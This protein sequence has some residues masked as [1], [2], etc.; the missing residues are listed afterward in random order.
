MF[1]VVRRKNWECHHVN[2][3][4]PEY[5]NMMAFPVLPP[6]YAK[7]RTPGAPFQTLM[8]VF[9]TS[10]IN[11]ST[12][13]AENLLVSPLNVGS[14]DIISISGIATIPMTR[15][16]PAYSPGPCNPPQHVPADV[17]PCASRFIPIPPTPVQP[18]PSYACA[19]TS[20][21]SCNT[22]VQKFDG[23]GTYDT[24]AE[25]KASSCFSNPYIDCHCARDGVC[26]DCL[27][28]PLILD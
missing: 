8:L 18:R 11:S 16:Q 6:N 20:I 7:Q 3:G 13:A 12:G 14:S 21:V 15:W 23:T 17:S 1:C 27:P 9:T 25:C 4:S 28:A 10:G 26:P 19:P 5:V 24:E 2:A 22:C